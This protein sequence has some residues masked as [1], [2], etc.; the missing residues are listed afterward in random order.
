MR[1]V[2]GLPGFFRQIVED[3]RALITDIRAMGR[4]LSTRWQWT[5]LKSRQRVDN[6]ASTLENVRRTAEAKTRMCSACRALIPIESRT[7]P[8]CHASPGRPV[9][10][11]AARVVENLLPGFVSAN[12]LILTITM[13]IYALTHLVYGRLT[14]AGNPSLDYWNAALIALGSNFTYFVVQGET[15]RLL[16]SV[17]LHG[18]FLHLAMNCYALMTVGPLIEEVFGYGKFLLFY[19]GTGILGSAASEWWHFPRLNGV[20]ASGAIFGLIGVAAVWGW[21]RGG[22]VGRN[23]HGQ[24]IQWAL[25]GL[26]MGFLIH[27][28]N[29]AHLGGL[30]AGALLGLIVD[31]RPPRNAVVAK[32]WEAMAYLCVLLVIGSFV[33]VAVRY[34]ATLDAL[35]SS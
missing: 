22:S 11:G 18:N 9:S 7:C 16:T 21:R 19:V 13:L 24:M 12:S 33:M 20:G 3:T 35:F 1:P 26:V 14:A 34:Q 25:Y 8:E 6:A 29:A 2:A 30:A 31:D 23:I 17:F 27:A 5:R 15:W 10:L 32:L 4:R 28:D